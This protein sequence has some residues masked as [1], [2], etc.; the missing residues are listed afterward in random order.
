M[1]WALWLIREDD[2]EPK[3]MNAEQLMAEV[4]MGPCADEECLGRL[5]AYD[6]ICEIAL[7]ASEG[8]Y[9]GAGTIALGWI[10]RNSIDAAKEA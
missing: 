10:I 7:K 9:S 5:R 3:D 4:A 8:K 2:M 6:E 1:Y